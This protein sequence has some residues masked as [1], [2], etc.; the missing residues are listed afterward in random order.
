MGM[1]AID[2]TEGLLTIHEMAGVLRCS[3][4]HVANLL[5]G[6]VAGA[7]PLVHLTI[8][9]RKVV[10]RVTFESWVRATESRA[11]STAALSQSVQLAA[12]PAQNSAEREG[13]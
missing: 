1:G 11:D 9:R 6:K 10:R 3:R 4:T 13:R 5:R 12:P 7:I 2:E 8:G